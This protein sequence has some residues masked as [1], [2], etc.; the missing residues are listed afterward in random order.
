MKHVSHHAWVVKL[1]EQAQALVAS[2]PGEQEPAF[3]VPG[4]LSK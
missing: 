3:A 4:M 2:T 1:H